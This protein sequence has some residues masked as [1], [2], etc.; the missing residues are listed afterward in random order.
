[1]VGACVCDVGV[2]FLVGEDVELF[3]GFVVC[4][5]VFLFCV[6]ILITFSLFV[7]NVK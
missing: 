7:G 5:H 2:Y 6:W 3:F 4:G 1:M